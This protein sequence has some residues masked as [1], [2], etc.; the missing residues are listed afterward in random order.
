VTFQVTGEGGVTPTGSVAVYSDE[1][2][3]AGCD[4]APLDAQGAGSCD[5]AL[6]SV[7]THT[8]RAEHSGNAQFEPSSAPGR[9]HVVT[10]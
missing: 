9:A 4:A 5:F 6:V 2:S 8:I 7:G 1:E 10:P 3:G